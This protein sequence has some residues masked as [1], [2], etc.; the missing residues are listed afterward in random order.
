[1]ALSHD[2]SSRRAG[3]AHVPRGW[4]AGSLGSST[5]AASVFL[6]VLIDTRH[7]AAAE[8]LALNKPCVLAPAPHDWLG[9]TVSRAPEAGV[10]TA[11]IAQAEHVL[12][13]SVQDVLRGSDASDRDHAVR[14]A[15]TR[16]I[17]SLGKVTGRR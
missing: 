14:A 17:L 13:T 4:I 12:E 8:N 15:L 7:R 2:P 9:E 10:Q 5:L 6:F 1:M 11:P 3:A 16:A